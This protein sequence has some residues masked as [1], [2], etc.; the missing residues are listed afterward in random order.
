M[1]T[2][3]STDI[4]KIQQYLGENNEDLLRLAYGT[5]E[6]WD[7]VTVL[8]DVKNK[9]RL[10]T[11]SVDKM[12]KPF[13]AD[14]S[15]T[16]NVIKFEPREIGV[17]TAKAD[18][19]LVPNDFRQ[20]YLAQFIGSKGVGRTPQD[21]PFEKAIWEDVFSRFGEEVNDDT[22]YLGV[23]NASGTAAVDVADGWGTILAANIYNAS[24]N[25]DG[26][27]TP[28]TTGALTATTAYAQLKAL[29]RSIP[30]KYRTPKWALKFY[31]SHA[32]YESYLDN[33]D[34]LGVNSGRGNDPITGDNTIWL[35]GYKG[36]IELVP[37]TWMGDS[38]RIIATPKSNIILAAD[39]VQQDLAT[40][41]FIPD[42]WSFKVGIACAI[43]FD[44]RYLPLIWCN[45]QV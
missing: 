34:S 38:G 22:A 21:L 11:L 13:V 8:P 7:Q 15:P 2:T 3:T 24:T 23:H 40:M 14:F 39:A 31:M 6:C 37:N 33:L 1:P 12:V 25:A 44:F 4:S 18:L 20:T 19:Q 43:G 29:A 35:R 28:I 32:T 36:I 17:Q 10:T 5:M 42:V 27:I 30:V 9:I 26:I 41:N 16:A 45:E